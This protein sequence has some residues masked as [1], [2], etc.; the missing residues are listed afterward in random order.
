MKRNLKELLIYKLEKRTEYI[1]FEK[2]AKNWKTESVSETIYFVYENVLYGIITLGDLRRANGKS[3]RI[4]RAF[5]KLDS[6]N[7]IQAKQFFKQYKNINEIP[8]ISANG[9]LLGAYSRWDDILFLKRQKWTGFLKKRVSDLWQNDD[10]YYFWG[11]KIWTRVQ[12]HKNLDFYCDIRFLNRQ[13][14]N[15]IKDKNAVIVCGSEDEKRGILCLNILLEDKI[16]EVI[17]FKEIVRNILKEESLQ[18]IC[19]GK[20]DANIDYDLTYI[21]KNLV[22]VSAYTYG[23]CMTKSAWNQKYEDAKKERN[24]RIEEIGFGLFPAEEYQ[25]EFFEDLYSKE[26]VENIKKMQ[27]VQKIVD[28]VTFLEDIETP[29]LN[30]KD[31][32]RKTF[33]QPEEYNRTIYFFGPCVTVGWSVEDKYTIESFLQKRINLSQGE[34]HVRV[35][36]CGAWGDTSQRIMSQKFKKGDIVIAYIHAEKTCPGIPFINIVDVCEKNNVPIGWTTIGCRHC[37]H[38]VNELIADELFKRIESSLMSSF[39]PN[40]KESDVQVREYDWITDTYIN[41]YFSDFSPDKDKV[42]GSIV[43]NCN[44]FTLG[45]RY[46]IEKALETVDILLVF[47]VEENKSLFSFEERFFMVKEG[48]NDLDNVIV[49]PSGNFILS[50][51]TFP[52]YFVKTIDTEIEENMEYDIKIFA[53]CIAPKL[54]ITY[55]FVGEEKSDFVTEKYNRTMER[56]LNTY[57]INFVEIPRKQIDGKTI[58]ASMVR[59]YLLN[60]ENEDAYMMCPKSTRDYL[61]SQV[62]V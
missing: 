31:G 33:Y 37:N 59:K 12:L 14:I 17:T 11:S 1:S 41:R 50:D 39:Q 16:R 51:Y 34:Y 36:N 22:G 29:L 28:G 9:N 20:I 56:V 60:G 8:V 57:D 55:R 5:F 49:F 15:N 43:M 2:L 21:L 10:N 7:I 19:K 3:V 35:V 45:H 4:N 40:C 61:M 53:E 13:N 25:K 30:V 18:G 6:W 32:C 62:I 23:E 44:P 54:N 38:K 26:Y 47:V 46:L 58:S 48:T 27:F 42:I 24:K 52:E